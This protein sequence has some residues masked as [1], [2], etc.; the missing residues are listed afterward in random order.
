MLWLP[1]ES[2]VE[3]R[4]EVNDMFELS[5]LVCFLQFCFSVNTAA[6]FSHLVLSC[7]VVVHCRRA[8]G[9]F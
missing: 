2:C 8:E 1:D 3:Q 7:H 9:G 5:W 4:K 6:A